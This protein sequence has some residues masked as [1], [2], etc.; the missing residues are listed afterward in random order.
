[1]MLSFLEEEVAVS[2]QGDP[3]MPGSPLRALREGRSCQIT[4][5]TVRNALGH[6]RP[7]LGEDVSRLMTGSSVWRKEK[8]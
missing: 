7:Y 3:R 6:H 8:A 5:V 2:E 1:M 4:V